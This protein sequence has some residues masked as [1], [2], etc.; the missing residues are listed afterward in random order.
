MFGD[1]MASAATTGVTVLCAVGVTRALLSGRRTL[2]AAR[3]LLAHRELQGNSEPRAGRSGAVGRLFGSGVRVLHRA[4]APAEDARS[5]TQPTS[6][7]FSKE[8]PP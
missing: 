7:N 8:T 1:H 5:R 3:N 2:F 6:T 4:R